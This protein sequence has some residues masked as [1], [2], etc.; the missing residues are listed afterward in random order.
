MISS[1][2][3]KR[4]FGYS[5]PSYI[6]YKTLNKA[7]TTEEEKAYINKIENMLTGLIEM[8]KGKPISDTKL[9]FA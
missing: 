5:V 1:E 6:M 2:L 3:F 7:T 4:Y 9:F 8:I